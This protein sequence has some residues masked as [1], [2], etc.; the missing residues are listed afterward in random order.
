M[1]LCQA[2]YAVRFLSQSLIS[3]F[4]TGGSARC[5]RKARPA[6]VRQ[7]LSHRLD[8]T[9]CSGEVLILVGQLRNLLGLMNLGLRSGGVPS[10]CAIAGWLDLH[11]QMLPTY[12]SDDHQ[13]SGG[14]ST[15]L[16]CWRFLIH[17]RKMRHAIGCLVTSAGFASSF[18]NI[19][20]LQRG[21]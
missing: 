16:S 10:M 12:A 21:R 9:S 4:V 3:G 5:L 18:S 11:E 20:R 6:D 7:N 14:W 8:L 1:G 15:F 17:F 19:R 2:A 13:A